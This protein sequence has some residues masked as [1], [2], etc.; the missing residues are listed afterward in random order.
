MNYSTFSDWRLS[1]QSAGENVVHASL[2]FYV[3]AESQ[4]KP[5]QP[6]WVEVAC[7]QRKGNGEGMLAY[8]SLVDALLDGQSLNRSGRNFQAAPLET[9]DP[10]HFLNTHDNW[11]SIYT[12]YGFAASGDK[13]VTDG[14]GN[15]QALTQVTH[16]RIEPEDANHLHLNF[17]ENAVNWLDKLH[18]TAGL[19]DYARMIEDMTESSV[20]EIERH[21][22][23]ALR[24]VVAPIVGSSDITHCALYDIIE[25]GWRFAALENLA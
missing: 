16:F 25:G 7:Y 22:Q 24:Q 18:R 20:A 14:L 15:L 1:L 17:G 5:G 23:D 11:L 21:A 12:V 4:P 6:D 8:L 19:P 13:L 10:R 3:L 9:V 2:P